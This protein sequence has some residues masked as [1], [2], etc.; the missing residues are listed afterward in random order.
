MYMLADA[1][2]TTTGCIVPHN[3]ELLKALCH[4]ARI[5]CV[6]RSYTTSCYSRFMS[7]HARTLY[8]NTIAIATIA[9]AMV[10]VDTVAG[11][12]AHDDGYPYEFDPYYYDRR[13]ATIRITS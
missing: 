1:T 13:E 7:R 5:H 6:M 10:D 8:T 11:A 3:I 9:D 4:N 12:I 2:R